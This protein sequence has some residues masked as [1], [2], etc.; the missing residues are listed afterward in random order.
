VVAL[1]NLSAEAAA[2][3]IAGL[4]PEA[5]MSYLPPGA[6]DVQM[7]VLLSDL[8]GD[9]IL[10]CER[11][12]GDR[13][14][15]GRGA[16]GR[17]FPETMASIFLRRHSFGKTRFMVACFLASPEPRRVGAACRASRQDKSL[18]F[19]ARAKTARVLWKLHNSQAA[20]QISCQSRVVVL[21]MFLRLRLALLNR[22]VSV[23]GI[24][25]REVDGK[26]ES[27]GNGAATP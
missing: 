15:A 25:V 27:P 21:H 26:T 10:A 19:F 1:K 9:Y 13:F 5:G 17:D 7:H 24:A 11:P 18:I 2:G 20:Q 14:A 16:R 6:P 22:G 8:E 3:E 12:A 4:P 23:D